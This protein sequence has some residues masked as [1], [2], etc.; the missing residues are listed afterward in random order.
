MEDFGALLNRESTALIVIDIQEKLF[1]HVINR[2]KLEANICKV[3]EFCKLI[4]IPILVTEQYPQGLGITVPKVR[5]A[6]GTAY[7]PIPKTAFSCFGEERFYEA[8]EV[9]SVDWIILI[10]IETHICVGQ[11]ALEG[12]DTHDVHILADCVSARNELDHQVAL[13]RLAQDGAV[14]STAEMFFYEILR[15]AKTPEHKAVFHLLK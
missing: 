4:D 2:E 8:L 7:K 5:E 6:L 14:V 13:S 1:P 12:L 11:T 9:L 15:K 10:G 3:I